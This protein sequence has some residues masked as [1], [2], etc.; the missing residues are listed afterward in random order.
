[1]HRLLG[2]ADIDPTGGRGGAT[3]AGGA[4]VEMEL[5]TREKA[6]LAARAAGE[7]LDVHRRHAAALNM[8][9]LK[10]RLQTKFSSM[11]DAFRSIDVEGQSAEAVV[12]RAPSHGFSKESPLAP[13]RRNAS[14]FMQRNRATC[15]SFIAAH[16]NSVMSQFH[17]SHS[18][19]QVS[20]YELKTMRGSG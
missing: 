13:K 19:F 14:S 7:A 20:F 17:S 11:R 16:N 12:Q 2:K 9:D 3:G 1:M 18:I 8:A 4:H 6:S 10:E 5:G 15:Q